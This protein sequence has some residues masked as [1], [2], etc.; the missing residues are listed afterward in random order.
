MLVPMESSSAVLAMISSKSVSICNRSH[1]RLID[2]IAEIARFDEGN[3]ILCLRT[4]NSLNLGRSKLTLLKSTFNAE[5]FMRRLSGFIFSDFS[6]IH[7]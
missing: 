5:N 4:E 3:E 6:E 1:A 7:S 2:K